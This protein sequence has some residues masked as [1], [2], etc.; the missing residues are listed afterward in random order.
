MV[1]PLL[2]WEAVK[3]EPTSHFEKKLYQSLGITSYAIYLLHFPLLAV[4][5]MMSLQVEGIRNRQLRPLLA[6]YLGLKPTE[7]T[8]GRMTYELRRLRLHGVIERIEGTHRYRLTETG[9]RTALFYSR[10]YARVLRPGLSILHDP[11]LI[12]LHPLAN[13]FH[14]LA[15]EIDDYIIEQIAA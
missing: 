14:R 11:R 13:R 5:A 8:P 4:L 1:F 7:I 10:V 2:I 12:D 6:Q 3:H 9:L 15:K